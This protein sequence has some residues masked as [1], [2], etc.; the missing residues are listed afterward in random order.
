MTSESCPP[1]KVTQA[2]VKGVT[3]VSDD[4]PEVR[5]QK[6]ARIIL[7]EMYQFLGLLDIDG[8]VLEINRAA[9]EGAG[10]CLEEVVGK[11]FWEARWWAVSEE[12]RHRVR[13]MVEQAK[14]GE[15]V[16]CDVEVFGD[17]HGEKTIFVDFSLTPIRDDEGHVAFLLPEGRNISEKI[18]IEAELTRKNGELQLALEKLREIDGFKTKFFANVSH[19]LR[20]PLALILGPV[21]QLLKETAQVDERERFRLKTIKRNAQSLLHQVNDLLD[22]ARIDAQQMPLAYVCANVMA[23]LRDVASSFAAAA[24]E[25]SIAL[26]VEGAGELYADVDRA[27]LARVLA[28]LLSN[29]FKFTPAGGR[30]CCAITRV[31]NRRFLLSVQDNG[32]GVPAQMKEQIFS[33]FAQG[34]DGLSGSGSGLGLNIVK[35]FV[36]LHLGTVVVLDAPGGGAIFQIEMPMRAPKGVFV[37]ES[38]EETG[39]VSYQAIDFMAPQSQPARDNKPGCS[40][41]LVVED[42]PDLRHFLYDVLIDDYNVTLAENGAIALAIA[43][44][45]PPDLVITD[46]M[47]PYFDG[48]QF[49]REL[50]A[51]ERFPNVP[52]LVLSARADDALRETLLDELVQD[53]LT[54]PFSPQELRA[55]VRNLVM[56]KRTVDIL[57]KE[58]NS[59]ASDVCELTAGLVASRK[60][61]QDGLVALQISERRWLGLYKNTAVGIALADRE[62]RILNANPALQHM[63]GYNETDIV[64][65]SFVDISEESQ[66]AMTKRNVHGLFDGVIDSYHVQKRY[67]KRSGGFLWANVS[68]SLIPAV[69][70]EGPRLAVIVEDI[71]SRKQAES[72]LAVT[73][74]ELARVARFTT[75]GELVAS[76][77]HEVNQPLSAIATNSQAALRW[78]ARETPDLDEV[79]AAL[80][81]VNRDASLAGDVITRIRNFLSMGGI[82]REV[83]DVGRLLD[84]LL[85]ML[86]SLLQESGVQVEVSIAPNL[87]MLQADLVQLQQVMLNLVVNAVEAMRD[88]AVNQPVLHISVIASGTEGVLFSFMDTGS[89]IPPD[90]AEKIF[91]ALFSTKRDGLGMGLAISRSIIENH[92]GRLRLEATAGTGANFVFNIPVTL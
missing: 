84:D 71:S 68:A 53:Y 4:N 25:R 61:L 39:L 60:S 45:N 48:E 37:R 82:R 78:L 40:R 57:Q 90:M 43:L 6:L 41:I 91:D 86:Q 36:E 49:V 35:E 42:N 51:S 29:A 9:L 30:I 19:E 87:P 83:L 65:V 85:L 56:V 27:K 28:N 18:A 54:K 63:L 1:G 81:R 52:V 46:L 47:M 11:P 79:V 75:M 92:G 12:S 32:P 77:A 55:R 24:E 16:R 21:D 50:R 3:L 76:I 31:A 5:R 26:L 70:P 17:L 23:L 2:S 66:R 10:V 62:G 13:D 20:T 64:G 38:T 69:D 44:E 74:A 72:S 33:R 88:K 80:K 67:E 73:Q 34:Q 22:L 8:I 14:R 89:G 59:Q 15:F 58:L 7:D